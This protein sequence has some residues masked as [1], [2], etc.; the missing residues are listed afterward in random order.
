MARSFGLR[1]ARDATD[2]ADAHFTSQ[3]QVQNAQPGAIRE[4]AEHQIDSRLGHKLYSL[5]RI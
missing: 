1:D 2:I 4:G 3:E 5:R